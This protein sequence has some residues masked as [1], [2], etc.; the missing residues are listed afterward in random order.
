MGR[1]IRDRARLEGMNAHPTY[2]LVGNSGFTLLELLI[3]AVIVA[4][5]FVSVGMGFAQ[6][7]RLEESNREKACVL[8]ELCMRA[9]VMQPR[10]TIGAAR[11][12]LGSNQ[13]SLRYPKIIFGVAF[14]TNQFLQ[15]TNY[16]VGV[17]DGVLEGQVYSAKATNA[18]QA[19]ASYSWMDT[20]FIKQE[21]QSMFVS[22]EVSE[23]SGGIKMCYAADVPN[24]EGL[25]VVS[26]TIPVRLRN[27]EY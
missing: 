14:E 21:R 10:V 25:G 26:V 17:Q 22:N 20:L 8:E 24:A 12:E 9:V 11:T 15:V 6:L 3:V 19:K 18:R 5:S 23:I 4:V 2:R 13:V 7:S 16:V 1:R 27:Q